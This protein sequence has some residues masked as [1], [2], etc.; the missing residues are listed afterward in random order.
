MNTAPRALPT[1]LANLPA[2]TIDTGRIRAALLATLNYEPY[3]LE[4][5]AAKRFDVCNALSA[6]NTAS[7]LGLMDVAEVAACRIDS[8]VAGAGVQL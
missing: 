2:A 1:A 6:Q 7:L 8:H 3:G 4:G 5:I